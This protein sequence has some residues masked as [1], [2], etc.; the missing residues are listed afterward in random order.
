MWTW[1]TFVLLLIQVDARFF[2]K[3]RD[4]F[5][6]WEN[7]TWS[8]TRDINKVLWDNHL[9]YSNYTIQL[10]TQGELFYLGPHLQPVQDA[11]AGFSW[12]SK[13][14]LV[15]NGTKVTLLDGLVKV[16]IINELCG[17]DASLSF[18]ACTCQDGGDQYPLTVDNLG[19]SQ[20]LSSGLS[21]VVYWYAI[22]LGFIT[23]MWC[24]HYMKESRYRRG[25]SYRALNS[26]RQIQEP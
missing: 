12:D 4:Q 8:R 26:S 11:Y 14:T 6:T 10:A 17:N 24:V 7:Q 5:I 15:S 18:S 23:I 9:L 3:V 20:C 2:L 21:R 13:M 22:T 25:E 1:V 16:D 19:Q